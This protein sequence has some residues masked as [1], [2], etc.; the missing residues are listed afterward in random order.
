MNEHPIGTILEA[1]KACQT[2][3]WIY[4][5]GIINTIRDVDQASRRDWETNGTGS[6][7]R[8]GNHEV[9]E[10]PAEFYSPLI[11]SLVTGGSHLLCAM[12]ECAVRE[13]GGRIAAMDTDSAMIVSTK[14]GG[15][16]PCAGGPYRI[17][18]YQ[19]G[20]GNAAIRVLSFAEV[21]RIRERFE[22]INP[23]RKT[24]KTP[25][26]R[27]ENENF[28]SNGNRQQL[29]FYGI[30]AKLYC[31]FNLEGNRLLVRK[32]SGHGLGFL[33]A[34]YSV[35]DW[36]RRT[37]RKWKENLSPWI[38]ETWHFILARELGLPHKP[39]SWFKQPA[40]MSVPITTPQVLARLG[41]FKDDLRP[42]TVMTVPFPKRETVRDPLWT[43]YFIMPHT[44]KL[45]DVHGRT[46]VNIVSGES[47]HIYDRCSS[48]LPKPPG[49]LYLRTM[50]DEINR[51]LSRAESK[52]C[53]PNGG[54][55]TSS[56]VGLLARRHIVA[57][58]FH[59]IGKEASTRW[60]GGPDPSMLADAGALDPADGTCREYERVVDAKYLDQI[61][62]EAK[63]FSTRSL[64]RQSGVAKCAIINL[65]KGKNTIKPRTLR[66]LTKAIHDL[67]NKSTKN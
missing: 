16:V 6:L 59:Y 11:T 39:P 30:S 20:S 40:V 36:Q 26:L 2:R 46:M 25:F 53:T 54:I 23:W 7:G 49:W 42:F 24:L 67:Q 37:G 31:L 3:V 43:G 55:C 34:P 33:Q 56:T 50:E 15:L 45:S 61:R 35:A 62:A 28:D 52:F 32:P 18:N 41:A 64:S 17:A 60:A 58:D 38:F 9:W 63:Q 1:Q 65:K 10:Q 5:V 12:L 51:I 14:H 47:F 4:S 8:W 27:L 48:R 22:P 13:M 66:K 29:N 21:D 57:G 44:E 19:E